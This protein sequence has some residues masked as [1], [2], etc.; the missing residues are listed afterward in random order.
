MVAAAVAFARCMRAHGLP[1]FPDP[2]TNGGFTIKGNPRSP[3]FQAAMAHCK[4]L[5]PGGGPPAPGSSTHPSA[6][7]L[8]QMR[9]VAHCM[10]SHGI[11]AFPD[12]STTVPKSLAGDGQVSIRNGVVLV[13]PRSLDTSSPAFVQAAGACG[14]ALQNH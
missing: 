7:A 4:N 2:S 1:N 10:R 6:Q 8:A 13:F 9:Q 14:F 11:S 12:P 5:L 3:G